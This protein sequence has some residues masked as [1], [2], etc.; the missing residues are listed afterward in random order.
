MMSAMG[1]G[2][3]LG[4]VRSA[5]AGLVPA[6]LAP[7]QRVPAAVSSR[8][9]SRSHRP[10]GHLSG[11][12]HV[13]PRSREP[14]TRASAT[15]GQIAVAG[16]TTGGLNLA[17][18]VLTQAITRN[19]S[20]DGADATPYDPVRTLRMV[21]HGLFFYGPFQLFWYRGLE[22]FW[23]GR[24][25]GN[26]AVKLTLNQVILGP[27]I[28]STLFAW[29]LWCQ[30]RADEIAG[31]LKADFVKT[32]LGG[33]IFWVPAAAVNFYLIPVHFRVLYMSACGML[34]AGFLSYVS[35]KSGPKEPVEK[36]K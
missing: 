11:A 3:R 14:S 19:K 23:P 32:L 22:H 17:S 28:I 6:L 10:A 24:T 33:W 29:N 4:G 8:S 34:W 13:K 26:F 12:S 7:R 30:G 20:A 9:L 21:A 35:E 36:E 18:D 27:I 16:L 15:L 1:V 5:T 31:K 25:V 2:C